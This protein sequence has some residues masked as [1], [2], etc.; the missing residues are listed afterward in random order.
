MIVDL[1]C[2]DAKITGAIGLDNAP[3]PGVDIVHDLL[4]FPYPLDDSCASEIYVN[5]VLE[6]FALPEIHKILNEAYR[7]SRPGGIVRI[8]VPHAF[9]V[10][11]WIDPTH[12][13]FFTFGSAAFW[14]FQSA[15]AY[16]QETDS[17]WQVVGT[18]ARV[19]WFNWKRYRLRRLD[20][21]LS[22]QLARLLNGL[23]RLQNWPGAADLLV[24]AIPIFFVEIGWDLRKPSNDRQMA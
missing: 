12:R 17:R 2:G 18:A 4:N 5:H 15:K 9:S 8:R 7:V 3:L 19:T 11:A 13:M 6:H 22:R 24:K 21:F 14:D 20:A 16:Y 10:A 23:L 1:G